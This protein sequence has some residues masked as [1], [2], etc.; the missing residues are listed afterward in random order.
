MT[1]ADSACQIGLTIL[2]K[3]LLMAMEGIRGW[4]FKNWDVCYIF[5]YCERTNRDTDK[6]MGPLDSGVQIDLEIILNG[7][8]TAF[9]NCCS[10]RDVGWHLGRSILIWTDHHEILDWNSCNGK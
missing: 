2:W 8:L 5:N 1:P 4:V 9:G 6:R 7:I 10:G 3:E